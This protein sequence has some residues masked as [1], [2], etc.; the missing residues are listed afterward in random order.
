MNTPSS[1]F[2]TDDTVLPFFL[3]NAQVNG[4]VIRLGSAIDD[5][6]KRHNYPDRVSDVLGEAVVLTIMLGASVKF[7]GRLILQTKSDGAI[8]LIVVQYETSGSVR[9]YVRYDKDSLND[10]LA[11]PSD[12]NVSL[13]G[14]GHLAM[15]IDQGP[16]MERYQGIV[17]LEGQGLSDAA[18]TYFR[19][20][21]QLPT[22]I[23]LA[24]AKHYMSD[25]GQKD[26]VWRWRAGGLMIQDTASQG[27]YKTPDKNLEVLHDDNADE[28]WNRVHLLAGTLEDHE[29][30]DPLLTPERLLYRLFHE[31]QV[32]V[33]N[34]VP[35][36]DRCKCSRDYIKSV[37][38]NFSETERQDMIEEDGKSISVTCEFCSKRYVFELSEL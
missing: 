15:T 4:R 25:P 5:I 6:I 20:S 36:Y 12:K 27:G 7:E 29:L 14:H 26:E 19:Q 9:A 34:T 17:P 11:S 24:V 31:E 1:P 38:L 21:E 28:N 16:D 35:I 2:A 37:L 10:I 22:Y 32:R 30:L 33:F 13:L 18:D 3:E 8:G 23:R